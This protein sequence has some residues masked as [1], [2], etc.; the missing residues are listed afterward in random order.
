[1]V[2]RLIRKSQVSQKKK[3]QAATTAEAIQLPHGR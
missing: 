3:K 1:M 2:C